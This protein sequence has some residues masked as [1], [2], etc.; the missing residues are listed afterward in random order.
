MCML[1]VSLVVAGKKLIRLHSVISNR[2][3]GIT[4]R[5]LL[6]LSVIGTSIEY[7]VEI[8]GGGGGQVAILESIVLR[9]AG[10]MLCCLSKTCNEAVV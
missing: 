7:G 8:C 10:R 3:I 1:E 5:R 2:D 6:L 4:V 9:G